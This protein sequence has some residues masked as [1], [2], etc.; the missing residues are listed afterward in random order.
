MVNNENVDVE[1]GKVFEVQKAI[2]EPKHP[3]WEAIFNRPDVHCINKPNQAIL[4]ANIADNLFAITI[5][6]CLFKGISG[7]ASHSTI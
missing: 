7:N 3:I 1:E 4:S 5:K 2:G 6:L